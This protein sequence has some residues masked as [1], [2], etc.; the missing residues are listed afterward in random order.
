MTW[1]KAKNEERNGG[2]VKRLAESVK[3]AISA[4][5]GGVARK[6]RL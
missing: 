6:R 4:V 3:L 5:G 1:K 2:G